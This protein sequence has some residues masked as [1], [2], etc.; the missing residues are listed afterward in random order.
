MAEKNTYI[1][2]E[3]LKKIFGA[4]E[5]KF[6]VIAAH[7]GSVAVNS[8]SNIPVSKPLVVVSLNS[9]PSTLS[10]VA[11]I[12]AGKEVH[13]IVLNKS[14]AQIT[15]PIPSSFK[16]TEDSLSIDAD[17]FGE[18]NIISDGSTQFLRAV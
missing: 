6:A 1:P 12:E 7:S 16:S 13:I 17:S 9:A 8:V 3:D 2:T 14:G 15:I 5:N 4:I 18:I 11:K 10:L